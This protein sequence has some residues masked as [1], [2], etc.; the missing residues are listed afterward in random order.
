VGLHV[1]AARYELHLPDARSLKG[2][3]AVLRPLLDRLRNTGA[4]V[5]EVDHHDLWQRAALGIAVVAPDP[6]HATE[7]MDRADRLVWSRP[8]LEVLDVER[9]WLEW[10]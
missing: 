10:D 4:S 8:D 9:R 2:K 1:V 5:S 6:T 3:R 7:L